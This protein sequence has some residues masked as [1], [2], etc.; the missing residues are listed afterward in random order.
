MQKY[1][2][3]SQELYTNDTAIFSTTLQVKLTKYLPEYVLFRDKENPN[4]DLL[5]IEFIRI[6]NQFNSVKSFIH[7]DI[8]LAKKLNATGVH[9]NSKQFGEI[10]YAK[11]LGLEVIISTH[12]HN[13]VLEAQQLGADAVTYSPI[14]VSPNKGEP[15]GLDDLIGLLSKCNIKIFALGGVV[16][17]S[18]VDILQETNAYGFASIRYFL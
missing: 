9:L 1:L 7:Q 18:Q 2:I 12:S 16:N 4:Y 14:F 5:A 8:D 15:K 13:E 3:T 17:K 11:S 6:C 10:S